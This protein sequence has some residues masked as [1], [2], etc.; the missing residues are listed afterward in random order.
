MSS[1]WVKGKGA[2]WKSSV[3]FEAPVCLVVSTKG[4]LENESETYAADVTAAVV[5]TVVAGI[6]LAKISHL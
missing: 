6:E 3:S 5:E 4:L 1:G 2:S